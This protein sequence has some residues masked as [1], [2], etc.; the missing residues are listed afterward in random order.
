L[1][2]YRAA[3]ESFQAIRNAGG[4]IGFAGGGSGSSR[5]ASQKSV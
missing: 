1:A 5:L 2:G 4:V 3:I